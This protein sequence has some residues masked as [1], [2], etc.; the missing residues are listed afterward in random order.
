MRKL[1]KI[2]ERLSRFSL[3]AWLRDLARLEAFLLAGCVGF[4]A[5]L[6]AQANGAVLG[7][8]LLFFPALVGYLLGLEDGRRHAHKDQDVQK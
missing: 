2:R 7:F 5:G 8:G 4:G 6:L 3:G 1:S